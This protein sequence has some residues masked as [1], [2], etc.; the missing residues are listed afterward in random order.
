MAK[1]PAG[2]G[3]SNTFR[4]KKPLKIKINYRVPPTSSLFS[5]FLNLIHVEKL[6]ASTVIPKEVQFTE[7]LVRQNGL[8]QSGVAN[9]PIHFVLGVSGS[10]N[11]RRNNPRHMIDT[12]DLERAVNSD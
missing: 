1:M 6:T 11:K 2:T 3:M 8:N 7:I 9:F 5:N 10:C 12:S 4:L